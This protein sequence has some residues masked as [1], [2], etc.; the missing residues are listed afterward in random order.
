M[1]SENI[2]D[3][4]KTISEFRREEKKIKNSRFIASVFPISNKDEAEKCIVS[5]KKEFFNAHHH[6]FAYKLG[7]NGEY[8]KISDDG[9]PSGTSGKPILNAIDKYDLTN[10][11]LVVSRYFGG[12]KLGTGGLRQAYFNTADYCLSK[13]KII[14]KFIEKELYLEFEYSKLNS[15]MNL[16]NRRNINIKKNITDMV[17]KMYITVRLN[18]FKRFET[19]L[20]EVTK[21]KIKI[22]SV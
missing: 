15:V 21:G 4:F 13:C 11:I 12:T 14:E 8:F 18:E 10:I 5:I 16:I 7:F 19:E 2:K 1:M 20:M 3:S 6:P 17:V 22:K 9:E